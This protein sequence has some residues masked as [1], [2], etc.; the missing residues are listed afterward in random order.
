[1]ALSERF[2][3]LDVHQHDSMVAAIAASQ[4]AAAAASQE[5]VLT[6]PPKMSLERFAQGAPDQLAATDQGV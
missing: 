3:A 2:V 4:I 1:M 6:P 5:V